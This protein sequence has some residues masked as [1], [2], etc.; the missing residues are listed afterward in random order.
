MC[1]I[2]WGGGEWGWGNYENSFY[3]S[4]NFRNQIFVWRGSLVLQTRRSHTPIIIIILIN[5]FKT[6]FFP[7]FRDFFLINCS[8]DFLFFPSFSSIFHFFHFS[9]FVRND[10]SNLGHGFKNVAI[11]IPKKKTVLLVASLFDSGV[12]FMILVVMMSFVKAMV[13]NKL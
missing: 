12:D 10:N 11:I 3:T 7:Y 9:D 4:V 5:L 2:L 13:S 8:L 1:F 6:I